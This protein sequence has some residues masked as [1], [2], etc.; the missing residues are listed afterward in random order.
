MPSK[1]RIEQLAARPSAGH[2]IC[3]NCQE[4][5]EPVDGSTPHFS[6]QKFSCTTHPAVTDPMSGAR[7][8]D[9]VSTEE[10]RMT[11]AGEGTVSLN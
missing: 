8:D 6:E 11:S 2:L 10:P 9:E 7:S 1:A 3:P 5:I 4:W